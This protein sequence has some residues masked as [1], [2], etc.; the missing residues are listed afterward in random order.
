LFAVSNAGSLVGLL[1]YP[2]VL[3]PNLSLTLQNRLWVAA[4]IVF[5]ALTLGCVIV[6]WRSS[7]S[8]GRIE[9]NSAS[10]DS[11]RVE[12]SLKRRLYWVLLAFIPSSLLFGVTTYITT[13]I[14]PTP[15]L[16]TIP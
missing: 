13:E 12:V 14:A 4:Y 7:R 5:S 15:L 9:L 11:L 2:L 8:A 3:E 10:N 16:W 1:S 6:L